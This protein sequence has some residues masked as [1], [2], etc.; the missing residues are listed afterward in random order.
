M[1]FFPFLL[2]QYSNVRK[3]E[4]VLIRFRFRDGIY[5]AKKDAHRCSWNLRPL[6]SKNDESRNMEA[7]MEVELRAVIIISLRK[8]PSSQAQF[9]TSLF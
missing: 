7:I 6:V 2:Q 8:G 5:H 1:P 4:V 9:L 3:R